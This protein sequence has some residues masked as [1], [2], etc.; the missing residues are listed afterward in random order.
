M[1]FVSGRDAL[2]RTDT[3]KADTNDNFTDA[4]ALGY[5]NW[6]NDTWCSPVLSEAL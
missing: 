5:F 4:N 2:P 6:R 1:F 3:S